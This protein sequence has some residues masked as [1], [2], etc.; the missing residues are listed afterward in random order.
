[1]ALQRQAEEID[2]RIEL[3]SPEIRA[4]DVADGDD[5]AVQERKLQ[6][7]FQEIEV[8]DVDAAD[9]QR[10]VERRIDVGAQRKRLRRRRQLILNSPTFGTPRSAA[11]GLKFQLCVYVGR[12]LVVTVPAI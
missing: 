3:A 10:I 11:S 12:P 6:I 5:A 8:D 9:R 1:M 4:L 7:L 2:A